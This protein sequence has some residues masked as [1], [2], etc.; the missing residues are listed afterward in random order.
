M[1]IILLL[2][3]GII[4]FIIQYRQRRLLF[5]AEKESLQK[6]HLLEITTVRVQSQL[7][8]MLFIGQEIHD[9][10]AQKLAFC[11]IILQHKDKN[12][13]PNDR[14]A[15][16]ETATKVIHASIEELR[17]LSKELTESSIQ[18]YSLRELMESECELVN[19][20]T[21]I[22]V[23]FT[24]SGSIENISF[25]IKLNL[26]R[27]VQEFLNN[28]IKH[29]RCSNIYVSVLQ[30]ENE[31]IVDLGDNGIGFEADQIKLSG[32]GLDNMRRR[33]RSINGEYSF[34][35][36]INEGTQLSINIQMQ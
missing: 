10:V 14:E 19:K 12:K 32:I 15:E 31:L 22:K 33:V 23:A 24:H 11:S 20:V 8:T 21:P 35:S 28:S 30:K 3:L 26:I 7:E 25:G 36:R 17:S 5:N 34:A 4:V 1:L 29:A 13:L 6:Q 27:I 2:V 16:L 18:K 9:S